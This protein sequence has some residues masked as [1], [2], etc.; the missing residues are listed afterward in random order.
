MGPRTPNHSLTKRLEQLEVMMQRWS[1]TEDQDP[2]PSRSPTTRQLLL[3]PPVEEST[4]HREAFTI[5]DRRQDP[6]G[7]EP[8]LQETS[9]SYSIVNRS[10][11]RPGDSESFSLASSNPPQYTAGMSSRPR[12]AL[13]FSQ[14]PTL[15]SLD[16]TVSISCDSVRDSMREELDAG[17]NLPEEGSVSSEE[18][19]SHHFVCLL[20]SAS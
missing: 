16:P 10:S 1:R 2:A 17:D 18:L 20:G 12:Q 5:P 13:A 8:Q 4:S 14:S 9:P 7:F 3:Q 15:T 11:P 19:V 6:P